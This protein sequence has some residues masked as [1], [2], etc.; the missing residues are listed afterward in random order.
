[1][2][3]LNSTA[4]DGR[5]ELQQETSLCGSGADSEFVCHELEPVKLLVPNTSP[6]EPRSPAAGSETIYTIFEENEDLIDHGV[7]DYQEAG[8][9]QNEEDK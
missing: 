4:N 8:A 5:K 7:Q 6:I 3:D 9:K 2:R 1:M